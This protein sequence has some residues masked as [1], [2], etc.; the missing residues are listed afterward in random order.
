M[1]LYL[2]HP[3]P[4]VIIKYPIIDNLSKNIYKDDRG[5]CYSYEK[6]EVEC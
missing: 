2:V 3:E 5:T 6:E 1:I 4:K